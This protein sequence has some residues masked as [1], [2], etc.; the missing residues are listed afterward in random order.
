[1]VRVSFLKLLDEV[2]SLAKFYNEGVIYVNTSYF[3]TVKSN[4][5]ILPTL[6]ISI[7]R[8]PSVFLFPKFWC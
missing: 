6:I 1:M 4:Y 8:C 5:K 2:I 3:L 7:V